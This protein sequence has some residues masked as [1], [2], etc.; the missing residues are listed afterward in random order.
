MRHVRRLFAIFLAIALLSSC[1]G[2]SSSSSVSASGFLLSIPAIAQ[3]ATFFN[4]DVTATDAS[5]H[6]LVGYNG[7][8]KVTSTDP[9]ADL[10]A[11]VAFSGG[12]AQFRVTFH[13]VGS[14]TVTVTDVSGAPSAT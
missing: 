6:T 8:V 11:P 7:S 12:A 4:V 3:T 13:T 1:G 2:G 5:G 14:Q 9:K 10:P